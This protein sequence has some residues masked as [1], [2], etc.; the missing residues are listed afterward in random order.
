MKNNIVFNYAKR[1]EL[2]HAIPYAEGMED[3]KACAAIYEE[4]DLCQYFETKCK[5]C[6]LYKPYL[7]DINNE[8]HFIKKDDY[9]VNDRS[10]NKSIYS[11]ESF[12]QYFEKIK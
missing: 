6:N 11:K 3:G 1:Q 10:G 4:K 8:M 12:E 7:V 9:I 5:D 2:V